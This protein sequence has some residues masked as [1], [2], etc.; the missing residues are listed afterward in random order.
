VKKLLVENLHDDLQGS[1][2]EEGPVFGRFFLLLILGFS[3]IFVG[4]AVVIFAA[5][6]YGGD[7]SSFGAF[8]FIGPF[9]IVFGAGSDAGLMIL[10][11]LFLAVL[12]IVMFWV[13]NRKVRSYRD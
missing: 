4:I 10:V 2:K 6:L 7:S 12:S 13:M 1:A 3:L 8:F 11:G 5:L 9:P